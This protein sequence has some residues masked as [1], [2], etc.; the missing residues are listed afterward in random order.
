MNRLRLRQSWK[1]FNQDMPATENVDH[2]GVDKSVHA[3]YMYVQCFFE[4]FKFFIVEFDRLE[5]FLK[6]FGIYPMMKVRR[7]LFFFEN[8]EHSIAI[9]SEKYQKHYSYN[10]DNKH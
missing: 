9:F 3:Y 5:S 8:I 6:M 4:V 10:S 2:N 7:F 1:S